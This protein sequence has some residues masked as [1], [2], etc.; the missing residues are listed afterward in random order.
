MKKFKKLKYNKQH[1]SWI[2]ED[3]GQESSKTEDRLEM[4]RAKL[5]E[6]IDELNKLM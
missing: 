4:I 2:D 5:D 6:I 3:T 1:H